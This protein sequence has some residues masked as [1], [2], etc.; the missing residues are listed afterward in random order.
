MNK[1]SLLKS[2]ILSFICLSLAAANVSMNPD[3]TATT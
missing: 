1:S 3:T 2:V